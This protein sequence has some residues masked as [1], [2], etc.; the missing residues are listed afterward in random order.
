MF[1][2]FS[3]FSKKKN[4]KI[5][6]NV[7]FFHFF[8]FLGQNWLFRLWQHQ[9]KEETATKFIFFVKYLILIQVFLIFSTFFP[10]NPEFSFFFRFSQ[11]FNS[12]SEYS[13]TKMHNFPLLSS[14]WHS[15]I[16][17]LTISFNSQSLN[18][19]S[20][21]KREQ[22]IKKTIRIHPILW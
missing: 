4:T 22:L 1:A 18:F 13:D 9:S 17:Q 20:Y 21:T 11:N 8:V 6:Y 7:L 16:A 2:F 5:S 3:H 10:K 14:F 15:L 12:F 19:H